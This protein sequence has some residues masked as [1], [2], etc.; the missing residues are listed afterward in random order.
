MP[1]AFSP[2]PERVSVFDSWKEKKIIWAGPHITVT[3]AGQNLNIMK[4]L[5]FQKWNVKLL[6]YRCP[7]PLPRDIYHKLRYDKFL[8]KKKMMLIVL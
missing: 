1:F 3:K 5:V 8:V 7:T 4:H 2:F 6:G